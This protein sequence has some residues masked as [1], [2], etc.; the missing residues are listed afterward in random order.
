MAE[1]QAMAER[2]PAI[3]AGR[4]ELKQYPRPAGKGL[5]VDPPR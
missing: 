3:R 5:R 2:D 1:A 4:L